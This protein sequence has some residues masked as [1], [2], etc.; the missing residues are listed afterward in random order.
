M[1]Q[2]HRELISIFLTITIVAFSLFIVQRFIAPMLWASVIA[3]ATFPA[4]RRF[5]REFGAQK[6]MAAF[7]FTIGLSCLIILPI[8]WLVSVLI[9]ETHLF[10]TYLVHLNLHGASA[11][12]WMNKLP[13]LKKEILDFWDENIGKPGGIQDILTHWDSAITPAG[14]YVQQIGASL[15]HRSIQLGFSLL[16]LFF[17]YRDGKTLSKQ[18][19]VVGSYCLE[20][21]WKRFSKKLPQA[22]RS[23]VNGTLAISLA[24]GVLLGTGYWAL[25]FPA[26]VLMG[27]ITAIAAMVPFLAPCLLGI[28]VV[29][30]FLKSAF[31]SGIVI[32]IWGALVMFFADHVVKPLLISGA[33]QLPFLAVLF[34]ILGGVE[35][36]GLLGLFV[37]PI[38]MVLFVTLWQEA[39]INDE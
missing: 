21:R 19:D 5:E 34:G 30:F 12:A 13:W 1:T 29:I 15:A 4:Y 14:Y 37:G 22:L 20:H 26:P 17:F 16:S 32:L 38:V 28:V 36:L 33:V 39:Q 11:P 25:G 2:N 23:I 8:L 10:A 24:I 7:L 27:F 18:I 3:I 35:T 6:N 31:I 9:K